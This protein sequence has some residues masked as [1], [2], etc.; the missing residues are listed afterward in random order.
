[1]FFKISSSIINKQRYNFWVIRGAY[2]T[3]A[4][5]R[6]TPAQKALNDYIWNNFGVNLRSASLMVIANSRIQK[7]NDNEVIITFPSKRIDKLASI[8]TYGTGKIQ[9]CPVLKEAFMRDIKGD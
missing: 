8:I 4:T 5:Y 6:F 1:M 3:A 7:N 9:G 2:F